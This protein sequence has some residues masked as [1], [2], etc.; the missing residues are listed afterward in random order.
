MLLR[1]DQPK[2][3]Q[4]SFENDTACISW[5]II[6]QSTTKIDRENRMKR[7]RGG[8][9]GIALAHTSIIK[10]MDLV[11]TLALRSHASPTY[12]TLAPGK[13][14]TCDG[15]RKAFCCEETSVSTSRI[16]GLG[17]RISTYMYYLSKNRLDLGVHWKLS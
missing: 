7:Y 14:L 15:G 16:C 11:K 3:W 13:G 12:G 5:A 4:M 1:H 17:E 9:G 6:S 2:F 8:T 10:P